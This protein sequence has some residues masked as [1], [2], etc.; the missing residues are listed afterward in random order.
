M[1]RVVLIIGGVVGCIVLVIG[2]LVLIS[3]LAQNP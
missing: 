3:A 2:L 1:G